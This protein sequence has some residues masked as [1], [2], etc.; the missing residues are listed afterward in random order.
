MSYCYNEYEFVG[1]DSAGSRG[2]V[3]QQIQVITQR[4]AAAPRRADGRTTTDATTDA[5]QRQRRV[6]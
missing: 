3:C 2:G 6:S 5:A 1:Q 4:A